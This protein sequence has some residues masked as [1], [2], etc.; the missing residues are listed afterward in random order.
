G[1]G[2]GGPQDGKELQSPGKRSLAPHCIL[3]HMR[4]DL[5]P[6]FDSPRD[7]RNSHL[8]HNTNGI[9]IITIMKN[10]IESEAKPAYDKG[11]TLL[12]GLCKFVQQQ[13]LE[14]PVPATEA[15][16]QPCRLN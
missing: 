15:V 10:H 2:G 13:L 5:V 7:A 6:A 1:W 8:H 12:S 4:I 3:V 11:F 14:P 9:I 16:A